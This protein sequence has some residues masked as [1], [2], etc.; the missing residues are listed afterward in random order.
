MKIYDISHTIREGMTVW[1]GDPEFRSRRITRIRDGE[2]TNVSAFEL[3]THTGTHVDA[4]LHLDDTSDDITNMPLHNF[5]GP[6]RVFSVETE[7]YIRAADI[8]KLDWKGVERVLFKTRVS[9]TT[10]SAFD[11]DF[12][13]LDDDAAVFLAT[14]G[15]L[16]VGIDTPSVDAYSSDTLPVHKILLS[17]GIAILENAL[18]DDVP[19][20][21]YEIVC[22]PLKLDGL[23]GSPVR[24]ILFRE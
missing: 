22:L 24:A 20:G 23:D 3:G 5:L 16:L 19:P 14:H 10:E 9:S 7:K 1:P 17:H 15:I 13:C 12:V 4:A 21:D 6:A 18:L 8:R 11:P 2:P